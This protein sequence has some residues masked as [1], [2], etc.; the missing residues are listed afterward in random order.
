MARNKFNRAQS[1]QVQ[2][3][4][5]DVVTQGQEIDQTD[6]DNITALQG[7]PDN[8]D[9]S[10]DSEL[11]DQIFTLSDGNDVVTDQESTLDPVTGYQD[12][13]E[14]EAYA[15]FS[16]RHNESVP[17]Q[18]DPGDLVADL[19]SAE[20]QEPESSAPQGWDHVDTATEQSVPVDSDPALAS[21]PAMDE[22]SIPVTQ[23]PTVQTAPPPAQPK[24]PRSQ[25][26]PEEIAQRQA[27]R[28]AKQAAEAAKWQAR[29]E[30]YYTGTEGIPCLCETC[31]NMVTHK[32][33]KKYQCAG[34]CGRVIHSAC[35]EQ[36][37]MLCMHCRQA[38]GQE[39]YNPLRNPAPRNLR[40]NPVTKTLPPVKPAKQASAKNVPT[41]QSA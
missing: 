7:D 41:T 22:Q 5:L 34:G 37:N 30:G 9:Q 2:S 11:A 21:D 8:F 10:L 18:G 3:D 38:E 15:Q 28:L 14:D 36:N 32:T 4:D 29:P 39:V 26:S 6:Q 31:G 33:S 23:S 27:E 35:A 20:T 24:T 25:L 12:L 13:S 16:E 17:D 1:Q 40:L 19:A